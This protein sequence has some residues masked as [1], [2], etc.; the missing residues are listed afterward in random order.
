MGFAREPSAAAFS[1]SVKSP[2]SAFSFRRHRYLARDV[3]G[4]E[5]FDITDAH[6]EAVLAFGR[7]R[8][9]GNIHD[10]EFVLD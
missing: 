5:A 7:G 3:G 2:Q 9:K 10:H 6:R 8:K 4:E 1:D